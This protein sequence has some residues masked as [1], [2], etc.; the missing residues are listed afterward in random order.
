MMNYEQLIH[1]YES[2]TSEEEDDLLIDEC[3][4]KPPLPPPVK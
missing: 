2:F 1:G 4:G 3:S